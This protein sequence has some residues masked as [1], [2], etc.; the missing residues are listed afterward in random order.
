MFKH[1][2]LHHGGQE[3]AFILQ[4]ISFHKSALSRQIAEAVRIRRRGGEGA[5][6]NSKAEFSRC[7]IP[8]LQLEKDEENEEL[9]AKEQERIEQ[10]EKEIEQ[11]LL[12]WEKE[13]V[14]RKSRELKEGNHRS[15]SHIRAREQE[16]EE[17]KK[18][19]KMKKLKYNVIG[20]EWGDTGGAENSLKEEEESP[21]L[22]KDALMRSK[23]CSITDYLFRKDEKVTYKEEEKS[24]WWR[25]PS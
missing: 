14:K 24:L 16:E 10:R 22:P 8:R 19:K 3:T 21:L 9:I 23:Q 25:K 20:E 15:S 5:I 13:H 17:D 4:P 7:R 11:E 2:E 18:P 6:L 1:G 12:T